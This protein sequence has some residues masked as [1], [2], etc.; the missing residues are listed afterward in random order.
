MRTIHAV[1]LLAVAGAVLVSCAPGA[2]PLAHTP[3]AG[4]S[5]AGFW[6]GLWHGFIIWVTFIFSLFDHSVSVYEVHNSGWSYNLGYA[7]GAATLHG[8]GAHAARRRRRR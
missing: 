3:D 8:G 7:I 6:L 5:V 4:G 1:L 2:D